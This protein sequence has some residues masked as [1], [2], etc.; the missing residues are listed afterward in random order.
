[1]FV[2]TAPD[3]RTSLP[4]LKVLTQ[5]Q[6]IGAYHLP[7]AQHC[8]QFSIAQSGLTSASSICK[9]ATPA[10]AAAAARTAPSV[11]SAKQPASESDRN[12]TQQGAQ[13]QQ[14]DQQQQVGQ[15]PVQ[16]AACKAGDACT[17]CHEECEAGTIVVQLPCSHCFHED[18]IMPWLEQVREQ[19]SCGVLAA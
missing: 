3:T 11:C 19:L 13:Q 18:C 1:M 7:S 12:D 14:Q 16:H 6:S 17:V 5:F 9:V 4:R 2:P 10:Q 8:A 15:Q